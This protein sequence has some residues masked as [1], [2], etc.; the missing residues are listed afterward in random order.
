MFLASKFD[1][2][3]DSEDWHPEVYDADEEETKEVEIA[4]CDIVATPKDSTKELNNSPS[5][6]LEG[7][8]TAC[9][10]TPEA[11]TRQ[12]ETTAQVPSTPAQ[13]VSRPPNQQRSKID[14]PPYLKIPLVSESTLTSNEYVVWAK[15]KNFPWWPGYVCNPLKLRGDLHYLGTNIFSAVNDIFSSGSK[16]KRALDITKTNPDVFKLVYLFGLH[17]L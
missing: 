16:H 14:L 7:Q 9:D 3:Y 6:S 5:D 17:E 12:T 11:P 2:P 15:R 13:S 4:E 10:D 8:T 1:I